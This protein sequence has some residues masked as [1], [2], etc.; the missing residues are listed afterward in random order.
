MVTSYPRNEKT[1]GVGPRFVWLAATPGS[2]LDR[3]DPNAAM[4]G[5]YH[6]ERSGLEIAFALLESN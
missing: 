2:L 4:S 1:G 5:I 3:Q 6:D